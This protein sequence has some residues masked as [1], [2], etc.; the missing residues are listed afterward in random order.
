[1]NKSKLIQR[2][3]KNH[4]QLSTGDVDAAVKVILDSVAGA[5]CEGSRVEVR[6]FGSFSLHHRKAQ[7]RRNPKSGES[8]VKKERYVPYF[9]A[10][11][12]LRDRVNNNGK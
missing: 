8:V 3:S 2:I 6:G 10:G 4:N 5:L 9:K 12:E 7:V 11:K 1:M